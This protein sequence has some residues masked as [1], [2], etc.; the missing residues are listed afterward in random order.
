LAGTNAAVVGILVAAL[1]TPIWTS[2]IA[3]PADVGVALAAVGLLVLGKAPPILV[4]V[5]AALA[6]QFGA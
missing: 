1:Y 5:L 3:G 2:V 6:G 4:V